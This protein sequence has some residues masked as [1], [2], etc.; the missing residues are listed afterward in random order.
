MMIAHSALNY[1]GLET[2]LHMTCVG[3]SQEDMIRYLEKAKKLGIRNI[4]GNHKKNSL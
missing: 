2:M 1:V 4:L 3:S